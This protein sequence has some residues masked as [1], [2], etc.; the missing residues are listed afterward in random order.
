MQKHIIYQK[1]IKQRLYHKYVHLLFEGA[2]D[3]RK[4]KQTHSSYPNHLSQNDMPKTLISSELLINEQVILNKQGGISL[5]IFIV[6]TMDFYVFI[7]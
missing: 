7:T 1:M 5:L 3:K 4:R 6:L 2:V